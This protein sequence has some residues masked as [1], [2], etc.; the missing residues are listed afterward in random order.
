MT[1]SVH[2]RRLKTTPSCLTYLVEM[3]GDLAHFRLIDVLFPSLQSGPVPVK[4]CLHRWPIC[5]SV[6]HSMFYGTS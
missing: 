4:N 1:D 2:R 5:S 6:Y 3:E